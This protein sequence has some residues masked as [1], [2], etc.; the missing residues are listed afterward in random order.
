MQQQGSDCAEAGAH[1]SCRAGLLLDPA[2]IVAAAGTAEAD[3]LAAAFDYSWF[4]GQGMQLAL[5]QIHDLTGLPW[6]V[7]GSANLQVKSV[8]QT[9]LLLCHVCLDKHGAYGLKAA[10][11]AGGLPS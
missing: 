7:Q 1:T 8:H 6:C 11:C 4:P 9:V 10:C 3:A 2:D 5:L